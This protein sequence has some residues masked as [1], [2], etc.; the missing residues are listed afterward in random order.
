[1]LMRLDK[2][3]AAAEPLSRA[4]VKQLLRQGRVA[5]DGAVVTRGETKL[6]PEAA[7]V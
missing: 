1:M 3:I 4:E 7:R 6:D 5:V 2:F